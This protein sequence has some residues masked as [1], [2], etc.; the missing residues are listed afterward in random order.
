MICV[1]KKNNTISKQ[2]FKYNETNMVEQ[3]KYNS[4]GSLEYKIIY[5]YDKSGNKIEKSIFRSGN[6]YKSTYKY[7]GKGKLI[8]ENIFSVLIFNKGYFER[9]E[10]FYK[11]DKKNRK[12]EE[13]YN[14]NKE[15]KLVEKEEKIYDNMG[16]LIE[17]KSYFPNGMLISKRVY[18][19]DSEHNLILEKSFNLDGS[20]FSLAKY[21]YDDWGNLLTKE[22]YVDIGRNEWSNLIENKCEYD[23]FN[24]WVKNTFLNNKIPEEITIRKIS[25]YQ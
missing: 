5:E 19:Y 21:K 25:Y 1:D 15:G 20:P 24:N 22:V 9:D 11:Y 10:S 18:K 7:N 17:R 4:A 16:N 8:Y 14:Y 12:Y 23:N 13:Y 3:N 6:W 2:E